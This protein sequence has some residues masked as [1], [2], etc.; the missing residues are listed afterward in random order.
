MDLWANVLAEISK[1]ETK[2]EFVCLIGDFN[3]HVGDIIP[4]NMNKKSFG[5]KLVRD[6]IDTQK[7]VLVN[8][9]KKAVGGPYTR[10]DLAD[11]TCE[12]KKSAL[13]LCVVS[14]ELFDYIEKLVIDKTHATALHVY[15]KRTI[16]FLILYFNC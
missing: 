5:G 9:T 4:G 15:L 12:S 14:I 3:R 8:A 2:G 6:L 7:Y 1:I 11:P 13:D 16:R 10:Y